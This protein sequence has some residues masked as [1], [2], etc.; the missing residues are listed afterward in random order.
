MMENRLFI[1]ACGR[2]ANA[3][4]TLGHKL[5][6]RFLL[7]SQ[8]NLSSETRLLFLGLNPGGR[9]IRPD[10]PETSCEGGP[11][12]LLE[13]WGAGTGPGNAPLQ[14]QVQTMF[15]DLAVIWPDTVDGQELMEKSL[16]AYYIP[17]RSPNISELVA[18]KESRCFARSLW[19]EILADIR[20]YLIITMDRD[21]FKDI[22]TIVR[23]RDR[24]DP[25]PCIVGWLGKCW[26]GIGLFQLCGWKNRGAQI[27]PPFQIQNFW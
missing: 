17:F 24:V 16:L 11:A 14:V 15:Q 2:I 5:G 6:Y 23:Q 26:S 22:V 4:Q 9:I 18:G 7:G 8:Q 1:K 19:T 21:S 3:Y 25:V 13:T 12:F 27:P 10:H 20:P